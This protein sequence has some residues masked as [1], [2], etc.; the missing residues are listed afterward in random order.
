M[1]KIILL[2]LT[3]CGICCCLAQQ[4]TDTIK[5][6]ENSATNTLPLKKDSLIKEKPSFRFYPN[7]TSNKI[8]IEI[9]AFEP[10][11]V[12]IQLMANTGKL[13]REEKRLVLS[14]NE[15]IVFMFS[16]R[17]GLYFLFL[18][19]GKIILKNKLVIL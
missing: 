11:Y 3:F 15:T 19:Q 13:L 16:E 2:F 18:K 17:P 8:E 5:S 1:K 12:K 7:P 14:G 10:G 4:T 6:N 9:K